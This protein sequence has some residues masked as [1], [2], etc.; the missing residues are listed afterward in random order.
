MSLKS[1]IP[2][3]LAVFVARQAP[4]GLILRRGPTRWF[5]L[6]LWDT[7]KDR[8]Q[9]GQWFHGFKRE[10]TVPNKQAREVRTTA[11]NRTLY[12]FSE[13]QTVFLG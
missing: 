7:K 12:L 5:Q 1:P 4:V 11:N 9:R 13:D 6:I 8:F 2:C 3:K 10:V